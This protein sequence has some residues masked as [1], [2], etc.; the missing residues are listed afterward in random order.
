MTEPDYLLFEAIKNGNFSQVKELF[1]HSD[2]NK[3]ADIEAFDIRAD[4]PLM[5]AAEY[6]QIEILEYLIKQGAQIDSKNWANQTPLSLAAYK[7]AIKSIPVLIKHGANIESEDSF[8]QSPLYRAASSGHLESVKLLLKYGANINAISF[9]EKIKNGRTILMN[10]IKERTEIK[11]SFQI[12]QFLLDNNAD[13]T[14][15]DQKGESPLSWASKNQKNKIAKIIIKKWQTNITTK[16]LSDLKHSNSETLRKL[17]I[18]D[19]LLQILKEQPYEQQ[20][21]TYPIVK[22]LLPH[23]NKQELEKAIRTNRLRTKG[24]E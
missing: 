12:I 5:M 17:L 10:T 1:T 21:A 4:R 3:R 15:A 16:Q 9:N 2:K 6:E 8:G 24:N 18:T 11:N 7:N 22:D 19:G 23:K 13:I 20:L 14:I